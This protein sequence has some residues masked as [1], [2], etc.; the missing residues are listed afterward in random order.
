[1]PKPQP[2]QFRTRAEYRWAKRQWL[3]AHGGYLWTT[4]LIAVVFGGLSGSAV[5]FVGLV[6]FA[7]AGTVYARSK[8]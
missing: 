7:L 5:V 1:M 8:P 4:L 2:E 3:K 6:L